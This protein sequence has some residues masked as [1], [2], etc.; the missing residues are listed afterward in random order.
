MCELL[1]NQPEERTRSSLFL[2][3]LGLPE[4][5]LKVAQTQ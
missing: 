4:L 2:L 1:L 5:H 3:A